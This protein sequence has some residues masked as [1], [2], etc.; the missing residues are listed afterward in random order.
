MGLFLA[1]FGSVVLLALVLI[2]IDVDI[3]QTRRIER[4]VARDINRIRSLTI[5]GW[6]ADEISNRYPQLPAEQIRLVRGAMQR[7]IAAV[8]EI[9]LL[10]SLWSIS[11]PE[12]DHEA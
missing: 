10:E 1:A 9:D 3:S 6:T 8:E 4:E 2:T 7:T 5:K 11:I 12:P